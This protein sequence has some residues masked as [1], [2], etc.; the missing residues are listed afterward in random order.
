MSSK[1][2]TFGAIIG[3]VL[4]VIFV[5]WV[6]INHY[7]NTREERF[8]IKVKQALLRFQNTLPITIRPGFTLVQFDLLRSSINFVFMTKGEVDS[9]LKQKNN[10]EQSK[11]GYHVW[12]CNWRKKFIKKEI[13][14]INIKILNETGQE[15]IAVEN[16]SADC[17]RKV[18]SR[19]TT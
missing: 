16:M 19:K 18:P 3:C 11:F 9:F 15:L 12:L 1:S 8:P 13:F 17:D 10:S 7:S 2:S 14:K 5:G 6:G 4:L